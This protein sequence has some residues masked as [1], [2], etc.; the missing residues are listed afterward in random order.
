MATDEELF[1]HATEPPEADTE[2]EPVAEQV[3]QPQETQEPEPQETA[4]QPDV[5]KTQEQDH[6][7][8]LMELLNER[9]K[10]QNYERQIEEERRQR[11]ALERQ[12][13]EYQAKQQPKQELPDIFEN[14]KAFTETIEQRVEREV[15]AAGL[16]VEVGAQ[17]G[18][19]DRCALDVPTGAA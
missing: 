16:H 11:Q 19:G 3:E 2:Q 18:Q 14:P 1:A 8:P 10:R 15:A 17:R 7:V 13:A 9:E 5:R 12:I 6:R 4:P